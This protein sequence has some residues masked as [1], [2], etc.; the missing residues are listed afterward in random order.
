MARKQEYTKEAVTRALKKTGWLTNRKIKLH[1]NLPALDTILRLFE[2]TKM[3][4]VWRELNTPFKDRHNYTKKEVGRT[5][6]ETGW[7]AAK[8]IED[9]PDLP[10]WSTILKL[11]KTTKINNVWKELK[12]R[13]PSRYTQEEVARALKGIGW[14][15]AREIDKHPDLPSCSTVFRIFKT[16]KIIEVWNQLNIEPKKKL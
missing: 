9:H 2:V 12:I 14:L 1:Q 8:E 5:L 16:T 7:L 13:F 6:K 3:S 11:F 15:T 4:E 10:S